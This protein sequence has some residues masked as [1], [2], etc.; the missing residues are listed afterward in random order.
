ML[1]RSEAATGRDEPVDLAALAGDCITDLLARSQDAEVSVEDDLEP[2]WVRGEPGLLERMIANLLD[3]GIQHNER[4]GFLRVATRTRA[5]G[6]EL[7]VRNGGPRID[8]E[9]ARKLTEPF[10]RLD[11]SY[12]GFG[13]GLSIVRSVAHVHGGTTEIVAPD[14]GGLEVR[15]HLPSLPGQLEASVDPVA[16]ILTKR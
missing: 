8:P 10:R 15:I 6:V 11:R 4:G 14:T 16:S 5:F 7:V 1:A 3:N 9:E 2:A 12:G 13:L